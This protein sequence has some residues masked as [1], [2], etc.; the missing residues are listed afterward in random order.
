MICCCFLVSKSGLVQSELPN[1]EVI[2]KT[3]SFKWFFTF[4]LK[5]KFLHFLTYIQRTHHWRNF[6]TQ[7]MLNVH[8]YVVKTKVNILFPFNLAAIYNSTILGIPTLGWCWNF[9]NGYPLWKLPKS[10]NVGYVKRGQCLPPLPKNPMSGLLYSTCQPI[11]VSSEWNAGKYAIL[12]GKMEFKNSGKGSLNNQ[13]FIWDWD[14]NLGR[15]EL[16]I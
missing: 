10:N 3:E 14:L 4:T 13:I 16:G 9:A 1:I 11:K 2:K 7:L 8:T 5:V 12:Q 6:I 15:K